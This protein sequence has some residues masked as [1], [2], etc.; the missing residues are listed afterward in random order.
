MTLENT[1]GAHEAKAWWGR[2]EKAS[3]FKAW[4]E[5]SGEPKLMTPCL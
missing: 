1:A 3:G 5:T 4:R 2:R